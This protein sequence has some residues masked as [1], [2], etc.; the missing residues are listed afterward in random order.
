MNRHL[1]ISLSLLV[2][3]LALSIVSAVS[4]TGQ[5]KHA[6]DLIKKARTEVRAEEFETATDTIASAETH[7]ND[8]MSF[9]GTVL[10]HDETDEVLYDFAALGDLAQSEDTGEFLSRS[11]TLLARLHHIAQMEK[12]LLHNIL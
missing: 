8:H 2:G 10:R 7:W 11:A 1:M 6:E 3:I 9:F 5:L 4:L 12:P